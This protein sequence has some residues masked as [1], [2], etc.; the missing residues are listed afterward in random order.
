MHTFPQKSKNNPGIKILMQEVFC[1]RPETS[2]KINLRD[3]ICHIR[4]SSWRIKKSANVR[5][6]HI[7]WWRSLKDD[8][9]LFNHIRQGKA[10]FIFVVR[11]GMAT[12]GRCDWGNVIHITVYLCKSNLIFVLYFGLWGT[13]LHT[14][15][16]ENPWFLR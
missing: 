13:H 3:T 1:C 2:F 4:L 8:A 10:W 16:D 11:L 7:C 15:E 5:F 9:C 12:S 6:L 14:S